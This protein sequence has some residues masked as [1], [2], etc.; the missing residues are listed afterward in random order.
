MSQNI[1]LKYVANHHRHAVFCLFILCD[2]GGIIR[3]Y[4]SGG[5]VYTPKLTFA[6]GFVPSDSSKSSAKTC[7]KKINLIAI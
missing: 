5:A 2:C 4:E 6:K 7:K 3:A 1:L